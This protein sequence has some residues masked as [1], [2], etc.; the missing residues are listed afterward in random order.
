MKINIK[1]SILL[2]TA[3]AMTA[4]TYTSCTD[5]FESTNTNPYGLETSQVPFGEYFVDAQL[6]IYYNP[7]NSNWAYQLIQNL[8]S[9]LY[10]GYLAVPT[11]FNGGTNNS[12]Y[13]MTDGWNS[14][15]LED[16]NLHILKPVASILASTEAPDLIAVA[17]ILRVAGMLKSVD[18]YGPI[19]YSK[20]MQGGLSVEY[21]SEEDIFKSFL[22]DLAESSASLKTFIAE[23]GDDASR[24]TFD[25]MCGQSQTTWLHFCNTLRMRVAMRIVN[26]DPAAAKEACEAA[27][28]DGVMDASD[29]DIMVKYANVKNPLLE[30][31]TNYNDCCIGASFESILK[32]YND[33]RL[34][35][36][37]LPVGWGGK[38][39]IKDQDGNPTGSEGEIHGIRNG[40][41]MS[42]KA[43][44][45]MFSIPTSTTTGS[46]YA[47]AYPLPILRFA[48]AFFLRA[49]GALR[50]W[51]M[52]GTAESL[53]KKGIEVSFNKYELDALS[54]ET[55]V[56]GTTVGADYVDPHNSANNI[57]AMNDVTV[58]WD[59]A[60]SK[61]VKLQKII[62]Q[63]WIAN[64]PE[65]SEGWA[66]F[67]RTGY[68]KLFPLAKNLSGGIIADGD[69]IKRM[70]FTDKEKN[71][72][73]IGYQSGLTLLGGADNIATNLWW[74][75]D[76][77]NF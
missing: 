31:A 77:S 30:I 21:D 76:G 51:N 60:A 58:S 54:Y 57:A 62:T 34:A 48:E 5:G 20:T 64:F 25:K 69:F 14:L 29:P 43:N 18:A 10:S 26:V 15:L 2:L 70:P 22:A 59:E 17:K 24:L 11:P 74:D 35:A 52:G 73:T 75:V 49:E 1:K 8:N 19:P 45:R 65:G 53:Y 9:D 39:D 40:T 12:K 32:G 71:S 23:N 44:Y 28:A 67:R 56:N 61:E 38:G 72:N 42:E 41:D 47:D 7:D 27:Y 66:M 63:R 55:Y 3:A 13:S 33:P 37:A 50:G 6:A 68:P 4:G 16:A 46:I 36:M